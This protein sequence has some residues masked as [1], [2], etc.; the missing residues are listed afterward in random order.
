MTLYRATDAADTMGMAAL[1]IAAYL[2]AGGGNIR[3]IRQHLQSSQQR[4]RVD[5]PDRSARASAAGLLG[6]P[7]PEQ[8]TGDGNIGQVQHSLAQLR[9]EA[10]RAGEDDS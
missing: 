6:R 3:D 10:A 9:G 2:E 1:L 5:G 8:N 7:L 4:I